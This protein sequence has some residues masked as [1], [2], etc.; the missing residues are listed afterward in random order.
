MN[1]KLPD[2]NGYFGDFGGRYVAESLMPLILEVEKAFKQ[3]VKNKKFKKQL[4][5]YNNHYSGRPSPLYFAENLSK[6]L[7]PKIYLKRDELNHTGSHKINNCIGQAL[8]AKHM[9]KTRIIA[10]TG[11]G[12]HGVATATICAL[13][14]LKCVI[15][16]GKKDTERQSPNLF[17]M[18]LL[19]AKVVSVDSGSGTLK[20]AM[21][22][23]IRDWVSNVDDTYYLIGTAAGPHPYP[24]MVKYFQSVIGLEARKQIL[25][26]EKKLP[27]YVIACIGGGSNAIGLFSAFYN[28]KDTKLI[29]IEAGGKGIDSNNHAASLNCGKAGILHGNKSYYIQDENGQIADT[30]SIS[31]G[32]DYPGIGPE[33]A[34]LKE[35][36][37][38][39]YY[40]ATD[41]DALNGF[42]KLSKIEGI[43]PALEPAHAIGWLFKNKKSF[44][45]NDLIILNLCGR[46][47]K[48]IYTVAKALNIEI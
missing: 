20:A 39:S 15:Y 27:N 16:M 24:E 17:R 18:K 5:Y 36:A 48:D 14:G 32:L 43:I 22:E 35:N 3:A 13:F 34:F 4:E 30:Y 11:A 21:N 45:T 46:G 41:D 42:Q 38:A 9:G 7:G 10:E 37:R 31:A 26:V 23:A 33:H 12:Q 29:G 25:K 47:D 19:G 6:E 1:N 40:A 2:I 28:D 8:L 44:S